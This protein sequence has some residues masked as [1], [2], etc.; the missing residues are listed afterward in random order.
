M[1]LHAQIKKMLSD[2]GDNTNKGQKHDELIKKEAVT[3]ERECSDYGWKQITQIIIVGKN[4][5][6]A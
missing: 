6:S 2:M 4:D 5:E 1:I 3:V